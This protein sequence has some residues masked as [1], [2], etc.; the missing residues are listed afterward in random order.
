M[1]SVPLRHRLPIRPAKST[2]KGTKQE[3]CGTTL[4]TLTLA[5][6]RHEAFAATAQLHHH[7]CLFLHLS[8]QP[9]SQTQR[10]RSFKLSQHPWRLQL[11]P[12][13]PNGQ[14]V[15]ARMHR[16]LRLVECIRYQIAWVGLV[17]GLMHRSRRRL[18]QCESGTAIYRHRHE[19]EAMLDVW[20][21]MS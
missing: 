7:S 18:G 10:P 3:H 12:Q 20:E 15:A 19:A 2:F 5:I 13:V 8:G 14:Q 6:Y 11:H 16:L 9:T 17:I 1:L 21:A 4:S